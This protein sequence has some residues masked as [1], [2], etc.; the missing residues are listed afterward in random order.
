MAA[1]DK[2]P[3]HDSDDDVDKRA[4]E[5]GTAAQHSDDDRR[6]AGLALRE[7]V[8]EDVTQRK[9]YKLDSA[10]AVLA[11]IPKVLDDPDVFYR[12]A[13][14]RHFDHASASK[15]FYKLCNAMNDAG[16]TVLDRV[17]DD[18]LPAAR[19]GCWHVQERT[20]KHGRPV[21]NVYCEHVNWDK[22]SVENMKHAS[23]FFLWRACTAYG[24]AAQ[25]HGVAF[26]M[27]M[28]ALSMS[29]IK[30]EFETFVTRLM[31]EMLPMRLAAG[32]M[33]DD[34]FM[35]RNVLWPMMATVL[36]KKM[37]ERVHW[38]NAKPKPKEGKPVAYHQLHQDQPPELIP[39]EQGGTLVFDPA[40]YLA[41]LPR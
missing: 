30:M 38:T 41:T 6:R 5:H 10:D 28:R 31:Q 14:V 34:T 8:L 22:C 26:G 32:Y 29:M 35:M 13:L 33:V 11:F 21:L 37:R 12:F 1:R 40:A 9:N 3:E 20:D 2:E 36:K 23:F 25:E 7:Y 17:T 15:R 24:Y 27:F 16:V 4:G 18:A 19:M 39:K